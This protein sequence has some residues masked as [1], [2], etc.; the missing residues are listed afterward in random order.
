MGRVSSGTGPTR[1]LPAPDRP[2]RGVFSVAFDRD[3]KKLITGCLNSTRGLGAGRVW[4][5]ESGKSV[6]LAHGADT[7]MVRFKPDD[8]SV[9]VTC[10]N[11]GMVKFW[12]AQTGKGLEVPPAIHYGSNITC[13][14]FS[15][16]GRF[17]HTL[18]NGPQGFRGRL[19]RLDTAP[20]AAVLTED[21]VHLAFRH[22]S[23]E[24]AASY[25]DGRP[26]RGERVGLIARTA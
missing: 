1:P 21:H 14:S 6:I 7:Q 17:L 18:W 9:A 10:G 2:T 4:D 5:W 12:A 8:P 23:R 24:F 22:D 16:D 20:P 15:P 3:G 13:G 19:W 11:D 26:V 25:P